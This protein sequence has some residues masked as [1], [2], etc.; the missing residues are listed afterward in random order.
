MALGR[1]EV[2]QHLRREKYLAVFFFVVFLS[3]GA[4]LLQDSIGNGGRYAEESALVGALL[5]ALAFVAFSWSIRVH[6]HGKALHRHLR[7]HRT[8][9]HEA[10]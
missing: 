4:Y 7:R 8:H 9:S 1:G 6:L 3:A 5:L 10:G 2:T